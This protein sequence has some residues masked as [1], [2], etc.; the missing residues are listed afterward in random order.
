MKNVV[1]IA[2]LSVTLAVLTGCD[3]VTKQEPKVT[4]PIPPVARQAPHQLPHERNDEYYWIRDDTRS[5]PEMLALLNA[6]NKYTQQVMAHTTQLQQSLFDEMSSRLTND[7]ASV[8]VRRG[9][10]NYHFEYRAGGEYPV[11]VRTPV[12][13]PDNAM[14]M[15][16]TNQLSKGHDYYSIGN[17]VV[18]PDETRLAYAEDTV[19]RREYTIRFKD[20]DTGKLLPDVIKGVSP[21]VAWSNDNK[22]VYYVRKDIQT[23]LPYAVYQHTL[24]RPASEDLLIYKE[25]DATFYTSIAKSRSGQYIV[26]SL[27][28]TDTNEIRLLDANDPTASPSVVLARTP[29]HEYRI[30]HADN[31]FYILSNWQAPNFRLMSASPEQL[32]DRNKWEEA[33]AHRDDVLLEDVEVFNSHLVVAERQGGLVNLT[34]MARQPSGLGEPDVIHFPEPAYSVRLMGNPMVSQLFVRYEYTSLT[35]PDSVYDYEF[36]TRTAALRKV[37]T[38]NGDFDPKNYVTERLQFDARDGE[39]VPISLVYHRHRFNK[40]KNPAYL[41]AYGSY[42]YSTEAVFQSKRLSLLDRGFV[43]VIIHIR[44]GQELG[45]HWYENGRQLKKKNT[46]NDFIDGTRHLVEQGYVDRNK[47]FAM[48]GSAGGLLMGAI[49]NQAPELYLGIVA[50]VPF[51]DVV[52]TMMDDSIPL[53]TGEYKEWG[54]PADKAYYDYMLS[55][56]PYDQ[57]EAKAYPHMLVTTGL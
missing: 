3:D 23:L 15:L 9:Q 19:S 11:Y 4:E 43:F 17:W 38:V 53:T 20:L 39:S 1:S 37:A 13:Q 18:S 50:K 21:S 12:D 46:F 28:S 2:A 7:D 8:P 49:A 51:V 40:G 45:R 27:S 56:S 10:F 22:T 41:Y 34:V 44:G 55:Y 29:G 26:I 6:E 35:R 33:I 16:D 25:S 32:F 24:G 42:G 48:G 36:A 52:T 5:N 14:T 47:V 57:V 54:N 30:R 31:T